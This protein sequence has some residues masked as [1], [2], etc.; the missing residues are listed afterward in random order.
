MEKKE[1][2]RL[3]K[4]TFNLLKE[5]WNSSENQ[6]LKLKKKYEDVFS[7][8][9]WIITYIKEYIL[10]K[11]P[12]EIKNSILCWQL[13]KSSEY[14]F[15]IRNFVYFQEYQ[16]AFRELRFIFESILKSYYLDV[17]HP[18]IGLKCKIEILKELDELYGSKLIDKVGFDKKLKEIY[19]ILCDFSH[20]SFSS[21][22]YYFDG[23][24]L[25]AETVF[26]SNSC[27][28]I[29]K[30][31]NEIMDTFYFLIFQI[32]NK[33]DFSKFPKDFMQLLKECECQRTIKIFKNLKE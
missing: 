2:N 12:K 14:L 21:I 26:D 29:C 3:K 20:A 32:F 4:N 19:H 6:A 15:W 33:I 13:D 30:L 24:I 16:T 1:R 25:H 8:H 9:I 22:F 11:Y 10:G 27:D 17:N 18:K 28:W 23:K 7:N 5:I 31:L